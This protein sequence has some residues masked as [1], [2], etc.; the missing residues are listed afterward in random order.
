MTDRAPATLHSSTPPPGEL[1]RW[2]QGRLVFRE[3]ALSD[4]IGDINR[5]LARPVIL[6][7]AKAAGEML[8]GEFSTRDPDGF[9]QAVNA[10]VG[11][12]TVTRD[13]T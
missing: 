1:F 3:T 6:R 4:A 2:R 9:V 12:G 11:P 8:S 5:Y 10:L 7:N 13:G